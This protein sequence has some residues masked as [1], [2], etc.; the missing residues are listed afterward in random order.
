MPDFWTDFCVL[1]ENLTDTQRAWLESQFQ[2]VAANVLEPTPDPDEASSEEPERVYGPLTALEY[3]MECET[4]ERHEIAF[5]AH[6]IGSNCHVVTL[7][8]NGSG[9]TGVLHHLLKSF[10][11]AF[12]ELPPIELEWSCT[13]D[14]NLPG[15]Y[16]GGAEVFYRGEGYYYDTTLFMMNTIDRL[17]RHQRRCERLPANPARYYLRYVSFTPTTLETIAG[18][19]GGTIRDAIEIAA[20]AVARAKLAELIGEDTGRTW[21]AYYSR[22]QWHMS[23][24]TIA[25]ALEPNFCVPIPESEHETITV[26]S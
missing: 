20:E 24:A 11:G 3:G 25:I 21:T 15:A 22:I 7:G 18:D 9:E 4:V 17:E 16:G 23:I 26:G 19:Q 12:P 6:R 14:R 5:A 2:H 13:A 10:S 8:N 1:I